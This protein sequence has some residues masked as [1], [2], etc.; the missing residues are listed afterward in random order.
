MRRT[1]DKNTGAGVQGLP[2]VKFLSIRA[3]KMKMIGMMVVNTE[4]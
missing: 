2:L 4:F 3:I 1:Y